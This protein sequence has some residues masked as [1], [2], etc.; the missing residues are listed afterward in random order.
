MNLQAFF[1]HIVARSK[2]WLRATTHRG[3]LEAEMEAELAHHLDLLTGDLTRAGHSPQEAAR[4]ARIALGTQVTHK[5]NMR[6]SLG[7]RWFDELRADVFYG[8]RILRKSPGFTS[9]C[10]RRQYS[11]LLYRQEPALRSSQREPSQ[12]VEDRWLA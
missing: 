11:H 3:R 12:P 4:R 7:L 6:A 2:S 9:P 8:L 1:D 10:H 5:E